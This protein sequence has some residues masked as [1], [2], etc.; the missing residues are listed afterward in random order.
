MSH[1][2]NSMYTV[3]IRQFNLNVLLHYILVVLHGSG[4]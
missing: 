4:F 1:H 2:L 3:I